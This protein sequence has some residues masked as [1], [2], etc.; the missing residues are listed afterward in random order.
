V[1]PRRMATRVRACLAHLA[2]D[3]KRGKSMLAAIEHT[4]G[5]AYLVLRSARSREALSQML[6]SG[7]ELVDIGKD[8]VL[9][10]PDIEPSELT[11]DGVG[12]LTLEDPE[13]FWDM[14]HP[15]A[16]RVTH[17]DVWR[18]KLHSTPVPSQ[19]APA[20]RRRV[21]SPRRLPGIPEVPRAEAAGAECPERARASRLER[22]D[23]SQ[24]EL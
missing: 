9:V 5:R 14:V 2:L 16:V 22:A 1:R 15:S 7:L 19:S 11:M 10:V 3:G 13:E 18:E 24:Q 12:F 6:L 4:D 17:V 21:D 8:R 20:D 23:T